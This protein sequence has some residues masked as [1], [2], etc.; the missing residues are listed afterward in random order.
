MHEQAQSVVR[1]G[2]HMPL[3][4]GIVAEE[5]SATPLRHWLAIVEDALDRIGGGGVSGGG[6]KR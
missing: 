3:L 6:L 5:Q 1:L 2:V 4:T